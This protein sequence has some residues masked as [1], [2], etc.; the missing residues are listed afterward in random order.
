MGPLSPSAVGWFLGS[1]S[2]A[3]APADDRA[4]KTN[5]A[6]DERLQRLSY[7]PRARN[8]SLA[9]LP[10][11]ASHDVS[12]DCHAGC[13]YENHVGKVQHHCVLIYRYRQ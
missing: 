5:P 2:Q 9:A 7:P 3:T 10:M 4:A 8:G 6:A 12:Q 13:I 1:L 11:D